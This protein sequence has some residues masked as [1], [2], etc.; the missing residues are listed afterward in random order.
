MK[1]R[2]INVAK[3]RQ[4]TTGCLFCAQIFKQ[5]IIFLN[6]WLKIKM[7]NTQWKLIFFYNSS[8]KKLIE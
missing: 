3:L 8:K 7:L 1:S 4:Q 5:L 6:E 2:L